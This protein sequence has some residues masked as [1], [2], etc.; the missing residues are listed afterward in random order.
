MCYKK[1]YCT[2]CGKEF[3][4]GSKY[5]SSGCFHFKDEPNKCAKLLDG[6]F[7]FCKKVVDHEGVCR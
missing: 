3:G 7:E 5:C 2:R 1:K 4:G 6:F